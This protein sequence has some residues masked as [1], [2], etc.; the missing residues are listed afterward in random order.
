MAGSR[1]AF[2]I[3][4]FVVLMLLVFAG[5]WAIGRMGLMSTVPVASL[6][7]RERQF[8]ERMQGS[9]LV[10]YFTVAGRTRREPEEDR[11]DI[12]SVE[13]VAEDRWRF[14]VRMRHGSFDVT[15]PVVVPVK[16]VE[17]T[18]VITLTDWEIPSLGTFTCRVLFHGDR[19]A[20]T[21]Q[22][23]NVGGLMYGR[24]EKQAAV[25]P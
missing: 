14:N 16:W 3:V 15:L 21:W 9:S 10:G 17:D 8:S 12:S 22:H 25:T 7:D 2:R 1:R 6:S 23:G 19:Y 18:P 5:G 24:I 4:A 20:G 11:Y 13:K